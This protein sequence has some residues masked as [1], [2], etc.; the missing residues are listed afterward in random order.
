MRGVAFRRMGITLRSPNP[1]VERRINAPAHVVWRLLVDTEQWPR[2]GPSVRRVALTD[3]ATEIGPGARGTV[4]TAVGISTSFVITEFE[5][6]RRWGWKVAGIPATGHEVIPLDD[7][8]VVRFEVPRWA[9][10]YLPV[11]AIALSRIDSQA[12]Q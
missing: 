6:G 12:V 9:V 5:P 7:G 1:G 4:W 11:C 2:W 10:A 8:C 3:G